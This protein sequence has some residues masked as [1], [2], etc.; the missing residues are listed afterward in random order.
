MRIQSISGTAPCQ[1]FQQAGQPIPQAEVMP[2]VGGILGDQHKLAH[3][4]VTQQAG[5]GQDRLDRPADRGPLMSGN[6]AEGT[7]APAAV[8]DFQVRAGARDGRP[9]GG[10]LIR[11]DG[12]NFGEVV[13]RSGMRARAQFVQKLQDV[14]PAARAEDAIHTE[15]PGVRPA[16][17]N[18]G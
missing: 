14:H 12:R 16:H 18:A 9:Q 15:A 11:A 13:D 1:A 4:P 6:G 8:S 3:A 17:R 10:M 5:F 2:V 7:R